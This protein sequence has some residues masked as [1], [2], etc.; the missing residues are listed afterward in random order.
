VSVEGVPGVEWRVSGVSGARQSQ[1]SSGWHLESQVCVCGSQE[2][3]GGHL[4]SQALA[5]LTILVAIAQCARCCR[6]R[7][8]IE[9]GSRA[10]QGGMGHWLGMHRCV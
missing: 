2:S 1:Q 5:G 9:G 8:S 4:G 7:P 6:R 10:S 3:S